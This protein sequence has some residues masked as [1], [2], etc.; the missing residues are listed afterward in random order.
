MTANPRKRLRTSPASSDDLRSLPDIGPAS[1]RWL[2]A[3]G[4]TTVSELRRVGPAAA[5][6]QIAYRFGSAVNRNLL[7][8]LAMGLQGRN[9]NQATDSEKRRL[10][11]AAGI[12]VPPV[13]PRRA[14]RS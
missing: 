11:E 8:A 13:R 14:A 4:V 1:E 5:Y 6:A 2:R 7:Y 10:C 9:Y 12:P 3:I